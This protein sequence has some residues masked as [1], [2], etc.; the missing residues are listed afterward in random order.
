MYKADCSLSCHFFLGQHYHNETNIAIT[1]YNNVVMERR[2][3][4]MSA[5]ETNPRVQLLSSQIEDM[6]DAISMSV[7]QLADAYALQYNTILEE[8]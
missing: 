5:S 6:R 8:A 3:L 4:M 2:R 7:D 1:E